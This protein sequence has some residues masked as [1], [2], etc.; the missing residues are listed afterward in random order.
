M[1]IKQRKQ[2]RL[3][4]YDYS[5][6]GMYFVT[7]CTKDREEML[8]EIVDGKMVLNDSGKIADE[9][10]K[11]IPDHFPHT[12]LDQYA[13]MPNHIHGILEI[14]NPVIGNAH[15]RSKNAVRSDHSVGS[16][17][18][19]RSKM[20]LSKAIHGFKSSVTRKILNPVQERIYAFPTK[21]AWQRSFYD[22]IIRNETELN[23]IRE[24]IMTNPETWHRDRNNQNCIQI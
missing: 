9:C 20:L 11:N 10:W 13:I 14:I 21:F 3:Q 15:V 5:Q 24:Y 16:K 17:N 4:N 18:N 7:I 8:G 6:N 19:D 1:P 23:K 22:H 2:N 12:R